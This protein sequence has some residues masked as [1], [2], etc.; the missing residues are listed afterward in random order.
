MSEP[1]RPRL[2]FLGLPRTGKS[3][4][5]GALWA[6]IQSPVERSVRETDFSG[7][8]SYV[9]RLAD[10]VAR[11]E[12][13]D[14]TALDA[15]EELAVE[16]SFDPEGIAELRIPDTSGE[17]LRIL[18]ERRIWYPRLLAACTDATAILFFVHPERL[19]LPQRIAVAVAGT[20]EET[21]A[22]ERAPGDIEFH[23][24]DGVR[25]QAHE[26]ECTAA[27]LI[28]VFENLA[29][30]WRERPPVRIGVV[31][32]AWDRVDGEPKPT[33]HEW[34]A[35]RLPGVLSTL[36][37]NRDIAE[38][39][40]FGVSAQGGALEDRDQLLAKGEICDRVFAADRRG[41]AVSLAEP[42]RWAIWGS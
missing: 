24:P 15:D 19:R 38:F 32:S 2:V 7:D 39:G 40:V 13:L 16:V 18:A 34:M 22:A 36:E 41:R 42:I 14:R 31:V 11:G 33:P 20:G 21:E 9:Q 27:E 26:H 6:L 28:D 3:T 1:E 5:L 37:S 30:L 4:F 23:P 10:Q 17:S 25:F 29:A 8:R 35:A 12:E